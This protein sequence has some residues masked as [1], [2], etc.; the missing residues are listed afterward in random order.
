MTEYQNEINTAKKGN[1]L[2]R[3]I[4]TKEN[5]RNGKKLCVST[6]KV[7]AFYLTHRFIE[8]PNEKP[9]EVMNGGPNHTVVYL[10]S[11]GNEVSMDVDDPLSR[12]DEG[13]RDSSL[14][15]TGS[16]HDPGGTSDDVLKKDSTSPI[17]P[18]ETKGD[19]GGEYMAGKINHGGLT[20]TE[21][22]HSS[23]PWDQK[24]GFAHVLTLLFV[25]FNMLV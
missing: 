8:V 9:L 10:R 5:I 24:S 1:T 4:R 12:D 23:S 25:H 20:A 15:G 19:G 17:S 6:I 7:S 11:S 22:P 18:A 14:E 16:E 2:S 3:V 13:K 21:Q